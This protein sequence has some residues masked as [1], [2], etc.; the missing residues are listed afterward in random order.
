M[1]RV[2]TKGGNGW[3]IRNNRPVLVTV[4]RSGEYEVGCRGDEVPEDGHC[5]LG[6]IYPS[7]CAARK[8]AIGKASRALDKAIGET[9]RLR[10]RLL[11][12]EK[13]VSLRRA[14]LDALKAE[15]E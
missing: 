5:L 15:D 12:A 9:D 10:D 3:A 14:D 7:E 13:V 2:W 8:V 11:G 6:P 1:A 4:W